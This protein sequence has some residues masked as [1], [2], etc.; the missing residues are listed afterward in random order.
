MRNNSISYGEI[1]FAKEHQLIL[2]ILI[3]IAVLSFWLSKF[4]KGKLSPM[5][6]ALLPIGILLGIIL[7]IVMCIHFAPYMIFALLL[8]AAGFELVAAF[9]IIL[10]FIRELYLSHLT[11][12][13]KYSPTRIDDNYVNHRI[14]KLFL[15]SKFINKFPLLFVFVFFIIAVMQAFVTLFGQAPNSIIRVFYESCGFLLSE[16]Q[17]C[18]SGGHYLCTVAAHG[19][20]K[21]VKPFRFGIRD[22][23]KIIINRQLLVANAFENW[24]EDHCPRT[25]KK[26][27]NI[28]DSLQ[29]PVRKWARKRKTA[30]FIYLI[31]KP[32]EWVFV[33]WLYLMDKHPENRIARQY[34][35][36]KHIKTDL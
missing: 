1:P 22:N 14:F 23:K 26:I 21:L 31:M 10:A 32:L 8:P 6:D 29:I 4:Y 5:L 2:I 25:Q 27:R 9:L 13:T 36:I 11:F 20:K 33:F 34:L 30:N 17:S 19:D 3:A 15:K 16:S 18:Y 28:Y 12:S 35:P 24:L 7:A